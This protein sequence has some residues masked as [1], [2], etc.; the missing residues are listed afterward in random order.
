MLE[1]AY[2]DLTNVDPGAV[3]ATCDTDKIRELLARTSLPVPDGS[4]CDCQYC[5]A[6]AH[7]GRM[8]HN[9]VLSVI[10]VHSASE[11]DSDEA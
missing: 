8:I 3:L 6:F 10:D 1:D 2:S 11:P 5:R 7:Y 9:S 4:L